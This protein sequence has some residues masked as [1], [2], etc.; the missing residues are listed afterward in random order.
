[1]KKIKVEGFLQDLFGVLSEDPQIPSGV[2][3]KAMNNTL[4]PHTVEDLYEAVIIRLRTAGRNATVRQKVMPAFFPENAKD[5][6]LPDTISV[7]LIDMYRDKMEDVIV[8]F[9]TTDANDIIVRTQE[10]YAKQG[11][12]TDEITGDQ[13]FGTILQQIHSGEYDIL[14]KLAALYREFEKESKKKEWQV[15]PGDGGYK[16]KSTSKKYQKSEADDI[17]DNIIKQTVKANSDLSADDIAAF[18]RSDAGSAALA[19]W[20]AKSMK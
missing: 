9:C 18:L 13:Y 2:G 5:C 12:N 15:A 1:M 17:M 20:L 16:G 11:K 7:K 6:T 19:G 4:K 14:D 8:E 10:A 3:V